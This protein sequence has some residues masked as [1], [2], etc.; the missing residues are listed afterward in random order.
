M[1][2]MGLM[3]DTIIHEPIAHPSGQVGIAA[4]RSPN[5]YAQL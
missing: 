3:I 5:R 4:Q 1:L 2:L